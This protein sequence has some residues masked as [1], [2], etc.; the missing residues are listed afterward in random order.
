VRLCEPVEPRTVIPIHYEGWL[1]FREGRDAIEREFERAPDEVR[2][3]VR[4]L[5]IGEPADVAV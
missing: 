2:R 3:S 5:A 4:W 1:H